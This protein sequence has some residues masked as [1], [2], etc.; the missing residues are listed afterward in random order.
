MED[1]GI[2]GHEEPLSVLC[3]VFAT[4]T[5]ALKLT[6]LCP[7]VPQNPQALP[8]ELSHKFPFYSVAHPLFQGD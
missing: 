6:Y 7:Q 3:P 2:L 8:H 1:G 4:S 5:L